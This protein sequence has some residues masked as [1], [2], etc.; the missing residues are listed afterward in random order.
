MTVFKVAA[1]ADPYLKQ[2]M[3]VEG[4]ARALAGTSII[5]IG[6]GL[7]SLGILTGSEPDEDKDL[8]ELQKQSGLREFSINMSAF[9]RNVSGE[10]NASDL[11]PGDTLLSYDWAQPLSIPLA[12]GADAVYGS[13]EALDFLSTT[14]RAAEAG[15]TTLTEQPLLTG[16]ANLFRYGDP[17]QGM[18]NALKGLPASFSPSL[19]SQVAQAMDGGATNPYS[20]Y[21]VGRQAWNMVANKLPGNLEIG[22]I[23]FGRGQIPDRIGVMGEEERWFGD[24]NFALRLAKSTLSPMIIS[25]YMPSEEAQFLMDLYEAS[26]NPDVIPN[27]PQRQYTVYNRN[28]EKVVVK[29][30]AEQFVEWSKWLGENT[31]ND[32]ADAMRYG[33]NWSAEDMA[34]EVKYLI[35][36]R[37][38]EL[39][40]MI[41]RDLD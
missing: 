19:L 13:G 27:S 17:V 36:E 1:E 7:A 11:R 32:I 4:Y 41:E 35:N 10:R 22:D 6:A 26:G 37:R 33:S 18:T 5:G 12:V 20:F 24:D 3:M 8:Y 34:D 2:R 25:E 38:K 40:D 21:P 29:P 39:K 30:T 16:V 14:V 28:D 23:P 9:I 15:V 31:K